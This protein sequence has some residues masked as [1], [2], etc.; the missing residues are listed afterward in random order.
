[1]SICASTQA[2]SVDCQRALEAK[3]PV[4]NLHELLRIGAVLGNHEVAA[5][6]D[7]GHLQLHYN[8]FH[9][10]HHVQVD[11]LVHQQNLP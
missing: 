5:L 2:A 6:H 1:M 4:Q 8:G 3:E 10:L 9:I 7:I 11:V